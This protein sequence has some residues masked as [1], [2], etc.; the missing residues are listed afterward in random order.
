MNPLWGC[1]PQNKD[2]KKRERNPFP[3]FMSIQKLLSFLLG[4]SFLRLLDQFL[5]N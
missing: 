2:I 4:V 5:G 3:F 1:N